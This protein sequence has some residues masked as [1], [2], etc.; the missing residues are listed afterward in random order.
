MTNS[1]QTISVTLPD[2]DYRIFVG[3]GILGDVHD[4]ISDLIYKQILIVSNDRVKS[5]YQDIVVDQLTQYQLNTVLLPDGEVY[6]TL[7]NCMTIIDEL[8][9]QQHHRDTLIIALGGGVVG[10]M[11][12]FAAALYQRGVRYI[13]IPTSL[14]AQVDSSVGGKTAV[15]HALGKNLIGAFH[16]PSRVIIDIE[17]LKTLPEKEFLA[18]IA[19]VIKYGAIMDT[20][21]FDWLEENQRSILN[22]ETPILIEMISRCCKLK[23]E[24]VNQDEREAGIR[25]LLNY[26]H[27]FGH[28]IEQLTDY[29]LWLHGEAVAMGMIMA[30]DLSWR[31]GVLA[32]RDAKRLKSLIGMF[33]LP[34]CPPLG[35]KADA[36]FS[37]MMRD[38]KNLNGLMRFIILENLGK[39]RIVALPEAIKDERLYQTLT[40]F[41]K[42]CDGE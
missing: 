4:L 12:G 26:G 1:F 27:T 6:K 41:E 30:A 25:A 13:Q 16:Q 28:A 33:G 42:L 5:L 23:A 15:N 38:K 29:K 36:F 2:R 20:V 31:M 17:T 14:L 40:Q 24:I 18:G 34:V 10:D 37:V 8:A 21:F 19:E 7:E 3:S 32:R 22:K 39:A 9:L 11:T 35:F